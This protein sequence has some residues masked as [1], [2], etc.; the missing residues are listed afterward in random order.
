MKAT[1]HERQYELA[2][3]LELIAGSGMFFAPM[4]VIEENVGYDIALVPGHTAVWSQLGVGASPV[5]VETAVAYDAALNPA[6][7]G[8]TFVA[9]L[10][11]QYKRPERMVRRNA[12][13]APGR[14][15]Q[16]GGVP[17]FRVR[18]NGNQHEVLAE[19]ESR[20]GGD[21]VVRYAAPLFHRIEDLWVRQSTRAVFA[22][23]AF[24]APSAAGNP[25]SCWTYDNNGAPIF[26][27]QPRRGESERSDDVLGAIVRA[28]GEARPQRGTHLR[29]LAS[30]I[31]QI[32]LTS[33]R[34]RRRIDDIDDR[35]R[36]REPRDEEW[37]RPPLDRWEW[38]ER[39][40]AVAPQRADAEI[41]TAVDAAV[42]ANAVGSIGLTWLLAEIRSRM[43][44]G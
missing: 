31:S 38:A 11:V 35:G 9:S 40:R 2:V 13:E 24:I 26:C 21:A 18:L 37:V 6:P 5:G 20:V 10:F 12:V 17:F 29:A 30:E 14:Q 23:S 36:Y 41:E 28:A 43:V 44:T 16:G 39:L 32:D 1:F 4:Q 22:G 15:S 42:V 7:G 3:N 8:Q 25:P 27:S 34:K 33:R 19:L